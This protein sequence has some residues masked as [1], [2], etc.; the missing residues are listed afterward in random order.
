[1]FGDFGPDEIKKF[2]TSLSA[3]EATAVLDSWDLW[4]MP[5]QRIP[6][7]KW[8]RWLIQAGRG[9]GKTHAAAKTVNEVSRNRKLVGNGEIGIVGRTY[10]DVRAVCVEGPSGILATAPSDWRPSW[11]PGNGLL[12]WP[13]GVRGRVYSGDKPE[14]MRGPNF[15]FVWGDEICHW[16]H[17]KETWWE[18]I[19][20]ALRIGWARAMITT[21]PRPSKFLSEMIAMQDPSNLTVVR[22]ASTYDNPWLSLEAKNSF[23]Q[24]YEGTRL[25]RQELLG[26][27]LDDNPNALWSPTLIEETR[28]TTRPQMVRIVVAIDPAVTSHDES[29]ETG[30]IVVGIGEDHHCYVLADISGKYKPHEWAQ[31]ASNA[32]HKWRA[33]RCIGETNQGGDMVEATLRAVD[34]S[35]AYEGVRATRGKIL[36]AEPVAA[37]YERRLVH[38]CGVFQHLE[39]QMVE[40]CPG[41]DSPDRLDALVH[42]ITALKLNDDRPPGPIQA[43]L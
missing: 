12:V 16:P 26:E 1:M 34:P 2:L 43:Y 7:G 35:I 14:G 5:H 8:R 41:A 3:E 28:V 33:D 30:I 29:N 10:D 13:N 24:H 23:I 9:T 19:E 20:P 6:E 18:V 17:P 31:H 15:A 4:A 22:R 36:R 11:Q 39:D 21:T 25:G 40:W 27:I 37:L 32:Y 38:H 42:G